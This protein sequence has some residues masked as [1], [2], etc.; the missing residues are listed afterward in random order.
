MKENIPGYPGYHITKD[1]KVYNYKSGGWKLRK[2]SN[3]SSTGRIRVRINSKWLQVSRLV[4]LAWVKNPNPD[5]YDV[6]MHLDNNP[7]NNYYKNLKW[8]TQSQNILQAYRDGNLK[9]P[10]ALIARREAH[11]NSSITNQTRNMIVD[12]RINYKVPESKLSIIFGI[13][14][15]HINKIVSQYKSG[16]RWDNNPIKIYRNSETPWIEDFL[17]YYIT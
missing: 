6:V 4:A 16:I 2:T 7:E 12:L 3:S 8:G 13:S 17:L 15:R 9:T 14:K 1:G 5:I 11:S 10:S